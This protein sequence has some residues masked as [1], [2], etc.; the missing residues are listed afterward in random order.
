V[1]KPPRSP[2]PP[3]LAPDEP[4]PAEPLL[5]DLVD[6]VASDLDWANERL[7]RWSAKRV[8]FRRCRLTGVGLAEAVIQDVSFD[9]CRVDLAAI[10]HASLERV[11]FRDCRMSECD[12]Y[13]SKLEDV[14]FERC[15]LREATFSTCR[16]E[17]VDF[18]DCDLGG[19][20]GAEDLRGARMTW[21]D[22]ISNA[23]LFATAL[24][25]EIAG[26][27]LPPA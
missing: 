7:P 20:R 13:G 9:E 17:R 8:E 10:R 2:Y 5:G 22:V 12:F 11:V 3:D 21:N 25:I 6:R 26:D 14:L 16:I 23:A 27:E 4:E 15:E 18:R 1:T 24:G 19:A